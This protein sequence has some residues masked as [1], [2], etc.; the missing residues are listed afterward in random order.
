MHKIRDNSRIIRSIFSREIIA[1][2]IFFSV[3]NNSLLSQNQ[4]LPVFHFNRIS[5]AN[6][7]P[8][9]EIRSNVIRDKLGPSEFI[10]YIRLQRARE[11]L[12]K[13]AGSI[14]EISLQADSAVRHIS[15]LALRKG[16]AYLPP[17][18]NDVSQNALT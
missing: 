2:L 11:M 6:G 17:R 3:S 4:L 18:F 13:N 16:L 9:N 12:E 8:I 15:A 5:M 10:Q 14:A 1:L 7:L